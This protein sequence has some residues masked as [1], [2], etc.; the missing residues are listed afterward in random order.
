MIADDNVDATTKALANQYSNYML[1]LGF[2]DRP[3]AARATEGVC[4]SFATQAELEKF[5]EDENKADDS[6]KKG[7]ETAPEGGICAQY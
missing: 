4:I 3:V 7:P 1:A 6:G 2:L 5:N